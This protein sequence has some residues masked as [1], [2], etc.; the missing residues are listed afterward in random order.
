[1]YIINIVLYLVYLLKNML[2]FAKKVLEINEFLIRIMRMSLLGLIKVAS[3]T[4]KR[5]NPAKSVDENIDFMSKL[6][7]FHC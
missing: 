2:L 7:F 5:T 6:F 3:K 1:M 4:F